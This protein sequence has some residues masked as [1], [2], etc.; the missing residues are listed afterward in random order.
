MQRTTR[1][2]QKSLEG[3]YPPEE[4][5]AIM[6][7][8]WEDVCEFSPVD[9][10]LRKD[11]VLDE[12]LRKKI[13]VI[14]EK[15]LRQE[16]IQYILGHTYFDGERFKVGSGVLIPRPETEELTHLIIRENKNRQLRK[17]ADIGTGSGCI[18]IALSRHFHDCC[19]EGWDISP[20]AL[21]IA[22]ENNR[23]LG[24]TVSFFQRD[25]LQYIPAAE[26]LCTYDLIVSNPPYIV[27]SEMAGMEPHV[28]DYE[29]HTALFV[30]EDD[31]LLFYRAI[32]R[33]GK[34]LLRK[35]GKLYFEINPIFARDMSE[36]L[37]SEGYDNIRT[38]ND[39]FGRQRF[40]SAT[41]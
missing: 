23:N 39:L 12:S 13:E 7:L 26:A 6:R 35:G 32:A 14:V 30:P 33:V 5:R 21:R 1:Y 27:P 8:I 29:P 4:I 11:T 16:P 2:I 41:R 9:V 10:I 38:D 31:P 37:S 22:T 15:L 28:L 24:A 18:A 19:I 25:I 34:G 40:T 3:I 20:E 36:M 17:I